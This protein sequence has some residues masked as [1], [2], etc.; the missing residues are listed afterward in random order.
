MKKLAGI[1]VALCCAAIPAILSLTACA[2][3]PHDPKETYILITGDTHLPYW[4]SMLSGLNRAASE[5]QVRAEMDGPENYDPKAEYDAFQRAVKRKPSGIL[6]WAVD[7]KLMTPGIDAAVAQG[8][9]VV[10]INADAPESRRLL[11]V[12]ADNYKAGTLAGHLV[13]DLLKDRG[14][15]VVFETSAPANAKLRLAGLRDTVSDHVNMKITQVVD[16][17][18]D[19]TAV[20]DTAKQILDSKVPVSAFVCISATAGPEVGEVVNREGM[21][22]KVAVIAMDSDPRTLELIQKGAVSA[23]VAQKPFTMAYSGLKFL[24][25]LHHHLPNP[26]DRDWARDPFSP[27]PVFIDTGT[28]VID[29]QNV[30][31][32]HQQAGTQK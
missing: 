14:N 21:A 31:S 6:L 24:D 22:G 29:K 8:I 4:Q 7:S 5:L 28:F 17:K 16:V 19:P 25:Q 2:P 26:L 30:A 27:V 32:V 20:F 13:V 15:I 11:Y 9:P 23:A 10:T 18:G 3:L 12:G 1:S